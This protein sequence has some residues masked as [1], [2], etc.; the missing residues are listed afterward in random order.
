M[1]LRTV[2]WTTTAAVAVALDNGGTMTTMMTMTAAAA[3]VDDHGGAPPSPLPSLL[4]DALTPLYL[5]ARL[6]A[7]E[8]PLLASS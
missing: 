3:A 8:L 5:P 6:V 1:H 4:A 2:S 7:F